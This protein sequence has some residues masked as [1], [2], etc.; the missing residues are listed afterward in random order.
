[1]WIL[2]L[3]KKT[4]KTLAID[5]DTESEN[6]AHMTREDLTGESGVTIDCNNLQSVSKIAEW[7]FWPAKIKKKTLGRI[8]LLTEGVLC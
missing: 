2:D 1:M 6:K 4:K 8:F 7:I 5:S 3:N